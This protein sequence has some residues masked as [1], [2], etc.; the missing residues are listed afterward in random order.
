MVQGKKFTDEQLDNV[1]TNRLKAKIPLYQRDIYK[2]IGGTPHL[3]RNYT[4]YGEV[5]KGLEL[6]D[7]IAGLDKDNNDRPL[8]DIKMTVTVL[9]RREAKRLEK[10][11]LP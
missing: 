3:D 4:V 9:K 6:V 10:E 5:V 1:E 2:A 7:K 8:T 11:L